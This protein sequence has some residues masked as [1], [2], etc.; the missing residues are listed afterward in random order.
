MSKGLRKV[1]EHCRLIRII[2]KTNQRHDKK[3]VTEPD[4]TTEVEA[5]KQRRETKRE[6]CGWCGQVA[7]KKKKSS[8]LQ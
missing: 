3:V 8:I 7:L 5:T 2:E 6:I 4:S 1:A